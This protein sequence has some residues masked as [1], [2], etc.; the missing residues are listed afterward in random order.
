M[1]AQSE[2]NMQPAR[3]NHV[4]IGKGFELF[5]TFHGETKLK[6]IYKLM[7]VLK[8]HFYPLY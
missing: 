2:V 7:F 5:Y 3:C 8:L 1:N 4:S 6:C